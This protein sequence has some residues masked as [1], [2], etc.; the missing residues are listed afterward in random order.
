LNKWVYGLGAL[1]LSSAR[2]APAAPVAPR[3]PASMTCRIEAGSG[4]LLCTV[5]VVPPSGHAIAWSDALVV[6]AP[7][8]ARALRG[9]AASKSDHPDQVVLAFVLGSGEG[10][11]IAVR[12]RAVACPVAPRRGACVPLESSV[13]FDFKPAS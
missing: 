11:R 2:A 5:S 13:S 8:S 1:V 6:S 7:S 12:A 9:R 3:A 4:R 10:G